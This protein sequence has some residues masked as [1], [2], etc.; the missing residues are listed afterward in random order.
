MYG[1][2][3]TSLHGLISKSFSMLGMIC[4]YTAGVKEARAWPIMRGT[5]ARSAAGEIHT[6]M[7]KGFIKAETIAFKD[8]IN[9]VRKFRL[10]G[11]NY[12]VQDGD[13]MTFRF[14]SD[15]LK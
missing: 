7:E 14:K 1:M 9:G 3:D 4:Y 15:K 2:E 13:V 6:D 10:E 12:I 11:P 8:F 5:T